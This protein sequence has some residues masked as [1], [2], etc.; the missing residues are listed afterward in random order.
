GE[1]KVEQDLGAGMF[2][3]I[4]TDSRNDKAAVSESILAA[5]L[6]KG[7]DEKDIG[8]VLA[9]FKEGELKAVQLERQTGEA[10]VAKDLA[11]G[12]FKVMSADSSTKKGDG[13]GDSPAF[14]GKGKA[15]VVP[16]SFTL[17]GQADLT[18]YG[19]DS[20]VIK[21]GDAK[22][23][24]ARLLVDQ[25]VSQLPTETDKGFS[26]VKIA[27]FPENLGGLDMDITIRNNKVHVV[28]MAD[29]QDVR[30][31]LQGHSDQLK[32]ALQNQ[33]L[34]VDSMDFLLRDSPRGM[35]SGSGGSHLS[36]RENNSGAKGEERERGALSASVAML[37]AAARQTG[38]T[39]E[40]G[41]SLFV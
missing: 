39:L 22:P 20:R 19:S 30:Q 25:I 4:L 31:A 15:A 16:E 18:V 21:P 2:K 28:L 6:E 27:L 34:L 11:A 7:I 38:G 14:S 37:S 29:R 35:D 36:W 13:S 32:S 41:I 26:R 17:A 23:V 5:L 40:G 12:M 3:A 8:K 24:E 33:G 1:A 9:A 10:A